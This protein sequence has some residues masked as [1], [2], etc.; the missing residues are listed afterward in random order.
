MRFYAPEAESIR[1]ATVVSGFLC[2]RE[3]AVVDGD[4]FEQ[5]EEIGEG[6]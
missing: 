3:S 5:I 1:E 2:V 6:D 4:A